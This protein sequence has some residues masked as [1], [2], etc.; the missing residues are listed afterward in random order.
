MRHQCF[1][2]CHR[3]RPGAV[4]W[5]HD[6]HL[7]RYTRGGGAVRGLVTRPPPFSSSLLPLQGVSDVRIES[8]TCPPVAIFRSRTRTCGGSGEGG[9]EQKE[10][11]V[12]NIEPSGRDPSWA[13]WNARESCDRT[14]RHLRCTRRRRAAAVKPFCV[15]R[16]VAGRHFSAVLP[17]KSAPSRDRGF[18]N[19]FPWRVP[20]R[21]INEIRTY[22]FRFRTRGCRR[23]FFLFF[24][25]F[26]CFKTDMRI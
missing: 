11:K 2:V 26:F 6:W 1:I 25:S 7:A 4:S 18:K 15:W 14:C 16:R 22:K 23:H 19:A 5:K 21:E 20:Y 9:D 24:L 8:G 12:E 17:Q 3:K 13:P 10:G